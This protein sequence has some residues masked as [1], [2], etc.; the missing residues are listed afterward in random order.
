MFGYGRST[1]ICCCLGVPVCVVYIFFLAE[2]VDTVNWNVALGKI[3]GRGEK[4]KTA[5]GI[6]TKKKVK[7]K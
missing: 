6:E 4:R 2:T 7:Q 3:R 1:R 5:D